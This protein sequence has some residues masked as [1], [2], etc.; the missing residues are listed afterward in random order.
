MKTLDMLPVSVCGAVLAVRA[1]AAPMLEFSPEGLELG[2]LGPVVSVERAVQV[3]NTGPV[4][5]HIL[6]VRTCCGA[7]AVPSASEIAPSGSAEIRVSLTTGVHPGLFRKTVSVLTDD[8]GRPLF[9][10]SLNGSVREARSSG[11]KSAVAAAERKSR[12]KGDPS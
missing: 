10:L 2:E 9:Q 1:I 7:K 5:V 12:R 11:E 4:P 3:R 6:R 8:P